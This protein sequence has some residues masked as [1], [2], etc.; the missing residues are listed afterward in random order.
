MD[1]RDGTPSLGWV[2]PFGDPRIEAC[3]RLPGAF[4]SVPRPSSPLDA[5]ASTR[6]PSLARPAPA[7]AP[8]G[9]RVAYPCPDAGR[10]PR[11]TATGARQSARPPRDQGGPGGR[12]ARRHHTMRK[13]T[14]A[15]DAAPRG[16]ARPEGRGPRRSLTADHP[17]RGGG[18][19]PTRT[20]DLTLIRRAL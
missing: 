2:A 19:G 10:P 20:A 8:P 5:K 12:L 13:G 9:R 7:A 15:A 6:C 3:S 4:R 17:R 18:P 11:G 14:G 16:T 1:S